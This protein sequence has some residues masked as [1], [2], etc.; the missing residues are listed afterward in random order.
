[1]WCALC[2]CALAFGAWRALAELLEC[3]ARTSLQNRALGEFVRRAA[4][5]RST[6]NSPDDCGRLLARTSRGAPRVPQLLASPLLDEHSQ[7]MLFIY[8]YVECL[9]QLCVGL[10]VRVSLSSASASGSAPLCA[11]PSLVSRCAH[12]EP[13]RTVSRSRTISPPLANALSNTRVV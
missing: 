4:R 12:S 13:S 11:R 8:S 1:M 7:S 10:G 6:E 2:N 3:R 9:P 5:P